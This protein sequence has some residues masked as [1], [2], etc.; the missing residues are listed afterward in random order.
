MQPARGLQTKSALPFHT[1]WK[2]TKLQP[3]D[4][5]WTLTTNFAVVSGTNTASAIIDDESLDSIA[6]MGDFLNGLGRWSDEYE[7]RV[8]HFGKLS[9]R[10]GKEHPATLT[11][12]DNLAVVLRDQCRR[13]PK[14]RIQS[15]LHGPPR[16]RLPRRRWV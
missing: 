8:F 5:P 15:L 10:A 13:A 6:V 11:S 4:L 12:M 7:I 16:R 14:Y 1:M 9:E 3:G 2:Q